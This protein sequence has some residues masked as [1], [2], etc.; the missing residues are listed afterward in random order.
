LKTFFK[1]TGDYEGKRVRRLK[2]FG[3]VAFYRVVFDPEEIIQI[4]YWLIAIKA[5]DEERDRPIIRDI[6]AF[7][8]GTFRFAHLR[9]AEERFEQLCALPEYAADEQKR[10]KTRTKNS[11]RLRQHHFVGKAVQKKECVEKPLSGRAQEVEAR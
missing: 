10:Q 4:P 1:L 8:N 9:E 2:Q 7:G 5:F 6:S 3:R 11:E